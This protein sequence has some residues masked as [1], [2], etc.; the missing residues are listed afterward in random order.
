MPP[1]TRRQDVLLPLATSSIACSASLIELTI[2]QVVRLSQPT[3]TPLPPTGLAA[4]L[5]LLP[6]L[7]GPQTALTFVQFAFIRE[8]RDGMDRLRGPH[9]LHLSLSYGLVSGPCRSAAY[10]LL[11][12][13]TYE[14]HGRASPSDGSFTR[15]WRTKVVPGLFWSVLRDSGSVGGGIVMAPYVV[16]RDAAPPVKFVG[17]LGCGACCGLAT[18]LFHN[19]ALTAGRMAEAG[20]RPG[21]VEAM[22]VCLAEHGLGALY[23]NYPYRVAVIALWTGILTVADP[24]RR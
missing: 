23:L 8:L 22:R 5:A 21:N 4:R 13:G 14:H 9:P 11:I 20:A 15:F 2:P 12:A 6:R 16:P 7:V 3:A 1:P 17:G 24:F 19:A 10:N 18:Q